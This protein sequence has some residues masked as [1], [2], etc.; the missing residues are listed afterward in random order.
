M[1]WKGEKDICEA[2]G[3]CWNTIR[4][5][6]IERG[7]PITYPFGKQPQLD[8]ED[9]RLWCQQFKNPPNFQPAPKPVKKKMSP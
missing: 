4:T 5:A 1:I 9:Y 8:S 3:K 6:R 7:L 2:L